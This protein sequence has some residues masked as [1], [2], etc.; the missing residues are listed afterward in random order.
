MNI[1]Q[2]FVVVM[3]LLVVMGAI[4][5]VPDAVRQFLHWRRIVR[6][7]RRLPEA[8]PDAERPEIK[9]PARGAV[10]IEGGTSHSGRGGSVKMLGGRPGHSSKW[11][12]D[13][14]GSTYFADSRRVPDDCE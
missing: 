11:P 4:V 13:G 6:Q 9:L 8:Q 1:Q 14:H 5:T 10:Y 12:R 2:A 3:V 7:A